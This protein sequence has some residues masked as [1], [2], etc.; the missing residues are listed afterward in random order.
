MSNP[1]RH[2][3]EL[4]R[5]ES[6]GLKNPMRFTVRDRTIDLGEKLRH[7]DFEEKRVT[8]IEFR[9]DQMYVH[10]EWAEKELATDGGTAESESGVDRVDTLDELELSVHYVI[11]DHPAETIE[12][13]EVH[14]GF[15]DEIVVPKSLVERAKTVTGVDIRTE[16]VRCAADIRVVDDV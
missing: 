14:A 13:Y 9:G 10:W 5:D 1:E 12:E 4:D 11:G 7:P 3:S 6:D 2:E 8:E 15:A 16:D